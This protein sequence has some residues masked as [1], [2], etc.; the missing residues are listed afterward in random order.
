[1]SED[2]WQHGTPVW[3]RVLVRTVCGEAG[4]PEP[5]LLWRSANRV[6]SSGVTHRAARRVSVTAGTDPIDVRLTLLHEL[7]HWLTAPASG[8]ARRARSSRRGG[9]VHHGRVFYEAAFALYT[10]YGLS[11]AE[12]LEREAARYPSALRHAVALG[13]PG[14][15]EAHRHRLAALRLRRRNRAWRIAVPEHRVSLARD[16][17]WWVCGTC[18]QRMVAR[19]LVRAR[20][21]AGRERHV[22]WTRAPVE[23]GDTRADG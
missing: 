1:V 16:G 8:T 14:A 12:S 18:G 5:A 19:A 21:R 13:L 15:V 7:A 4:L 17:R 10:R 11:A 9:N 6:T 3:A 2:L 22:L 23:G 20:R